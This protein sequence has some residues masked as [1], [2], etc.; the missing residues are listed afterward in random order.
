MALPTIKISGITS[1]GGTG[2]PFQN[3]SAATPNAFGASV[4]AAM[5]GVGQQ[6]SKAGDVANKIALDIQIEDN[7]AEAKKLDTEA[8][9]RVRVESYGGEL[10]EGDTSPQSVRKGY[11]NLK[12]E[13]AIA[14]TGK[15]QAAVK[16]HYD[17]VFKSASNDAVKRMLRAQFDKSFGADSEASSKYH[18][19][20]RDNFRKIQ[21]AARLREHSQLGV[22]GNE[23]QY[24]AARAI[25]TSEVQQ[26]AELNG[27]KDR[28]LIA[29][30]IQDQ[31]ST[32]AIGRVQRLMGEGDYE[33]AEEFAKRMI[34]RG[35][36]DELKAG[37]TLKT[38]RSGVTQEKA[39]KAA[40]VIVGENGKNLLDNDGMINPEKVAAAYETA[41]TLPADIRKAA[42]TQIDRVKTRLKDLENMAVGDAQ[43][44]ALK[45]ITGGQDFATWMIKNPKEAR[46]L[47]SRRGA[48]STLQNFER[49][50]VKGQLYADTATDRGNEVMALPSG[51]LKDGQITGNT[52]QIGSKTYA[53]TDF[54]EAQWKSLPGKISTAKN[55][56]SGDAAKTTPYTTANAL[57]KE[58]APKSI[59]LGADKEATD[60]KK[61]MYQ[62]ERTAIDEW[63]TGQYEA[64]GKRKW[65]TPPEIRQHIR[66]RYISAYVEDGIG[67]L[68]ADDIDPTRGLLNRYATLEEDQK[69]AVEVNWQQF[70]EINPTIA[71]RI[72]NQVNDASLGQMFTAKGKAYVKEYGLDRLKAHISALTIV[73][74]VERGRSYF[75]NKNRGS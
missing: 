30:S 47:F 31:L 58:I 75:L 50:T 2:S 32:M 33:G 11:F 14:E 55:R 13:E 59:V 9:R 3:A 24:K 70:Q 43:A 72:D 19:T 7:E 53:S 42:V 66:N 18:A 10:K 8:A 25:I 17:D 44:E 20:Q 29:S 39:F 16:K 12:N 61:D 51:S 67:L 48:V 4:G 49:K 46:L 40:D 22:L 64:S 56:E 34:K 62:K 73:R 69:D 57:L 35:D 60:I 37:S 63:I 65:P 71:A 36:L 5:Q 6:I 28:A 21:S 54:T 15:Y 41:K 26:S 27:I 68:S 52:L 23:N 74:D 45:A 38:L 1:V